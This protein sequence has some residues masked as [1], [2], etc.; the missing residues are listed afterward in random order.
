M[1]LRL[2]YAEHG[3]RRQVINGVTRTRDMNARLLL[4]VSLL[5]FFS[6]T[7]T[8]TM[9]TTKLMAP[10][11]QDDTLRS[12]CDRQNYPIDSPKEGVLII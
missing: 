8:S 5:I 12:A 1:G 9:E 3:R 2:R 11:S 6:L 10:A 4:P 7:I